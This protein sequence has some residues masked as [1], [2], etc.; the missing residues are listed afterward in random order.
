MRIVRHGGWSWGPEPHNLLHGAIKALPDL[1]A[2]KLGDVFPDNDNREILT[3]V[4]LRIPIKLNELAS[5]TTGE[6]SQT[7]LSTSTFPTTLEERIDT[8]LKAAL[9]IELESAPINCESTYAVDSVIEAVEPTPTNRNALLQIL[10]LWRQDG[11]LAQRLSAFSL[12]ALKAWYDRVASL[13]QVSTEIDDVRAEEIET[14]VDE[15]G[16][17]YRI[18]NETRDA[19]LRRRLIAIAEVVYRLGLSQVPPVLISLVYKRFPIE[20]TNFEVLSHDSDVAGFEDAV[21]VEEERLRQSLPENELS[22]NA[23]SIAQLSDEKNGAP[24]IAALNEAINPQQHLRLGPPANTLI[25]DAPSTPT[26]LRRAYLSDNSVCHVASA[27]P[28]LL[29]GPLARLGYLT[30]LNAV[31]ETIDYPHIGSLF[32]TALALKVLT[33]PERG[34]RRLSSS[35]NSAAAFAGLKQPA[36]EPALVKLAQ[37]IVPHISPLE[38][39]ITGTLVASHN[40]DQPVLLF[41]TIDKAGIGFLLVDIDGCFPIQWAQEFTELR[42][43]LIQ[44][45]SSVILVP[46]I[47]AA[48]DLLRWLDDEGFSFVTSAMP[49]RNEAWRELR[50]QPNR[51]CWTNDSIISDSSAFSSSDKLASALADASTLWQALAVER[52]SVPLATD[53]SFDR[54]LTITA[55]VALG[56]IAW[57]LWRNSETT[58]PF[59]A[60]ERF[61]S[62]EG[63][64]DYSRDAVTVSLPLGKRFFDLQGHGLLND[65]TDVPWFNGR[66]VVF[67]SS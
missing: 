43:T 66:K 16:R 2:A 40:Q 26:Q 64:V 6:V 10:T 44:L 9:A 18:V 22:Q 49:T 53:E 59:L 37:D 19:V 33:P 14:I 42:P 28:F 3:P 1:I 36:D 25:L 30:T 63:R 31:F 17:E 50:R 23:N 24:E 15:I 5:L 39:A 21:R 52:P 20:Q 41:Q 60:L 12:T 8:A 55:S 38:A 35:V 57:K 11:V 54:H 67:T 34:W 48:P 27:L 46:A 56:F 58:A 51:R 29:L 32:A 62:L 61:H 65:V 45:E 7:Y 47:S 13:A 4:K